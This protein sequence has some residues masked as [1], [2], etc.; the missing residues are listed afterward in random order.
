MPTKQIL[1]TLLNLGG[2]TYTSTSPRRVL[3]RSSL[4]CIIRAV[5]KRSWRWTSSLTI[6]LRRF[7]VLIFFVTIMG[8]WR[9]YV[10][11]QENK[12]LLDLEYVQLSVPKILG[13]LNK[14]FSKRR[15]W[16]ASINDS[17]FSSGFLMSAFVMRLFG[18][19]I[20]P[21][22]SCCPPLSSRCFRPPLYDVQVISDTRLNLSRL[23]FVY[24]FL[25]LLFSRSPLSYLSG[26]FL[27]SLFSH[28]SLP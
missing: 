5:I 18:H 13:L 6:F 4:R 11:Q 28:G 16:G 21:H 19:L 3:G 1:N 14:V 2:R 17:I 26:V 7:V 10:Q 24:A 15:V 8:N 27:A 23:F 22:Q 12:H 25:L 20:I 9:E